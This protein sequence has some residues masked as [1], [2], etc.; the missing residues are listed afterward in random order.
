MRVAEA[1]ACHSLHWQIHELPTC[2]EKNEG[3]DIGKEMVLPK[4][5]LDIDPSL[6][7]MT[8]VSS[9]MSSQTRDSTGHRFSAA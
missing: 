6:K 5:D 3:E 9:P 4:V 1:S 2:V 8:K 7:Q